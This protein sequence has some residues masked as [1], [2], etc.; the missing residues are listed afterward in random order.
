MSTRQEAFQKFLDQ[1]RLEYR[2]SLRLKISDIESLWRDVKS[3]E[4]VEARLVTLERLAHTLA[5]TAG[6]FGFLEVGL[7]AKHLEELLQKALKTAHPVLPDQGADIDLALHRLQDSVQ[8][9][10]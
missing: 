7:A 6:T 3:G 4:D 8:P 2:R 10:L 9:L 5:G 1:Q